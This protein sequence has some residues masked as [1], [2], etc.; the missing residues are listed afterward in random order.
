MKPRWIEVS[1]SQ[2]TQFSHLPDFLPSSSSIP[3]MAT[4]TGRMPEAA[5]KENRTIPFSIGK[6]K[7]IWY[8]KRKNHT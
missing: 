8:P 6:E 3:P 7:L 5:W 2:V 4:S 1:L